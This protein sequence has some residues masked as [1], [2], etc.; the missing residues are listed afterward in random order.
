MKTMNLKTAFLAIVFSLGIVGISNAQRQGD[1]ERK[2]L[3]TYA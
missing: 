3:P 2:E 1:N